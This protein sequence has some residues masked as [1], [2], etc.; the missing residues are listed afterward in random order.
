MRSRL[1][2]HLQS[3]L[4]EDSTSPGLDISAKMLKRGFAAPLGV[5]RAETQPA[6]ISPE[7]NG[8]QYAVFLLHV[9]AGIEHALMAQYLYAA[10]SIGGAQVPPDLREMVERWQEVILGIAKEEMGHLITVQ[11]VLRLL[12]GPLN[13]DREDYPFD[14]AFYPFDFTLERLTLDSLC[15]YIYAEMPPDWTTPPAAEVKKRA[16]DA[17]RGGPLHAVHELYDLMIKTIA[18]ASLVPDEYFRP[19]TVKQQASWSEWGRGYAHGARG[20]SLQG[21]RPKTPDL[22]IRAVSSRA[23]A[24]AALKE[25]AV[26]GEATTPEMDQ[27]SHFKR[28]LDIYEEWQKTLKHHK[29]FDPARPVVTNPIVEDSLGPEPPP[30]LSSSAADRNVIT[31]PVTFYWAHLLN[32]RYRLLLSGLDHALHLAGVLEDTSQPTARGDVITMVFSEMYKIRSIAS[33]L[34]QLPVRPDTPPEKAAAG[35]PFQMPYTLDIPQ[36]EDDRWRWHRD[37]LVAS[38]HI[39]DVLAVMESDERRRGYVAA[40]RE[41]DADFMAV[42]DRIIARYAKQEVTV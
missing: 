2:R 22:I 3:I 39:L 32:V 19:E 1:S 29:R 30:K 37:M 24:V 6:P 21:D 33:V 13:F 17:S 40:L 31:A 5:A 12:S 38:Q 18:D 4:R 25:I 28:F 20:S 27:L 42:I 41:S 11:N 10:Y 34:V 16:I 36:S 35:P 14:A 23:E 9:A 7:L 15:K 26:Q 8:H